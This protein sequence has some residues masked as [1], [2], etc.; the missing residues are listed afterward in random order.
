M[1]GP[2][3]HLHPS[4]RYLASL[5]EQASDAIISTDIE[6]RIAT[7]N[8]AA[9]RL[10]GYAEDE[11]RGRP[12]SFLDLAW[13]SSEAS[14]NSL[15]SAAREVLTTRLPR[16][17]DLAC[18]RNDDS[19]V[20]VSASVAPVRGEDGG[21]L[22]LSVIA[23]DVSAERRADQA[24]REASRQRDAFLAIMSHELRT[25]LTAILGYSDLLLRGTAGP[26]STRS[27][28]Y[29]R[30]VREAG[31]RLLALVNG[32]L[33]YSRLEAGGE[34]LFLQAVRLVDASHRAV[35]SVRAEAAI[36]GITLEEQHPPNLGAVVADREKLQQLLRALLANALKFTPRG[37]TVRVCTRHDDEIAGFARIGITDTGRGLAPDQ[38]EMIW[39][40]FYQVDAS[41]TRENGGVGLGLAIARHLA[42]LQGGRVWAESEG[43]GKGSTFWVALPIARVPEL[44]VVSE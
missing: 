34:R 43:L 14:E 29:V 40:R 39:E 19:H 22:G 36:R 3:R 5:L 16:R 25:P 8:R 42:T 30:N 6:G 24:M 12:L 17:V 10:F 28:T 13:S 37:G 9:E 23:H 26:L 41:L 1:L 38:V 18:G 31:N 2:R 33:E 11:V 32:L 44:S 4:E 7:W 21:L 20:E 15:E 35:S 27:G